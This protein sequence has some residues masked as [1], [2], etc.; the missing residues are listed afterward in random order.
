MLLE[1]HPTPRRG[2]AVSHVAAI[3]LSGPWTRGP[4]LFLPTGLEV[5]FVLFTFVKS[6]SV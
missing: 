3:T 5:V 4:M 2:A 6:V 1:H